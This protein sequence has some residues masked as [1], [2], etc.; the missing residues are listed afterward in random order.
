MENKKT[1][2]EIRSVLVKEDAPVNCIGAG[3]IAAYD[4]ALGTSKTPKLVRRRR[5]RRNDK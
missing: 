3:H 1:L 4:P 2:K 5:K